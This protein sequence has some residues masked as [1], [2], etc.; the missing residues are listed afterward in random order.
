MDA[1]QEAKRRIAETFIAVLIVRPLD[2]YLTQDEV[3]AS[4][5]E[6]GIS[7]PVFHE[8]IH[9]DW[10]DR[11]PKFVDRACPLQADLMRLSTSGDHGYP[12]ELFP[13]SVIRT[14]NSAFDSLDPEHGKQVGKTLE[15][16]ASRC[17]P[18]SVERVELALGFLMVHRR[19]TK[20][21]SGYVRTSTVPDC[22]WLC[23]SA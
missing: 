5:V 7:R 19:I 10:E 1:H 9:Q 6:S 8:V 16:L 18:Q 22:R 2:P 3:E 11:D 13:M 17:S 4:V 20:N 21:A 14:L 23:R 12:T 15:M